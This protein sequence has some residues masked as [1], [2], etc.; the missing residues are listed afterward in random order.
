MVEAQLQYHKDLMHILVIHESQLAL[1]DSLKL[2]CEKQVLLL[3][4]AHYPVN[5]LALTSRNNVETVMIKYTSLHVFSFKLLHVFCFMFQW[6]VEEPA[7]P[8]SHATFSCDSQLVY[9]SFMDGTVRVFTS[10]LQLQCQINPNAYLPPDVSSASH[11]LVIAAHPQ[12]PNQFA[13]GLTD[14]T[15]VIIE[16]LESEDK[17]GMPPHVHN[18]LHTTATEGSLGIGRQLLPSEKA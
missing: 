7:A 3:R 13:I 2:E 16:P 12:E 10:N 18:G 8:I 6:I 5:H 14:G 17:W 4:H 9:A 1:Y 11:P 15:V